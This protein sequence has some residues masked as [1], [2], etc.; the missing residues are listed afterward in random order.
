MNTQVSW[1]PKCCLPTL[2]SL[3]AL[4]IHPFLPVSYNTHALVQAANS[5]PS[6]L[7]T[8]HSHST[9]D[10]WPPPSQPP[11]PFPTSTT[12]SQGGERERRWLYSKSRRDTPPA[13]ST[14][15]SPL[16]S[17]SP[18]LYPTCLLL[19]RALLPYASP[20]YIPK[21]PFPILS[22]FLASRSGAC[23]GRATKCHREP[24]APR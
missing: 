14:V 18:L 15:F 22:W 7:S 23:T 9:S 21:G 17:P 6:P 1:R 12:V 8:L 4:A 20:A 19:P 24:H 3:P 13:A 2:L 5:I 10:N 16:P 11:L